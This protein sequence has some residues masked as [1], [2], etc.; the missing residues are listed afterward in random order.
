M[1][2]IT[3]SKIN[4]DSL[5]EELAQDLELMINP[6]S[7]KLIG[8]LRPWNQ[9]FKFLKKIHLSKIFEYLK[10]KSGL[11]IECRIKTVPF[12][13]YRKYTFMKQLWDY[14]FDYTRTDWYRLL[15]QKID[16]GQTVTMPVKGY[17][18][19]NIQHLKDYCLD[20]VNLL[21]SMRQDGY[22]PEKGKDELGVIIGPDGSLIKSSKGRHRLAAAQIT[23][24]EKIP[25]RVKHIHRQWVDSHKIG[26]KKG[27]DIRKLVKLALGKAS[28]MHS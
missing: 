10:P 11:I 19:S 16:N 21:K 6:I 3:I 4:S 7:I 23:G 17:Q 15:K 27:T 9:S 2:N 18:I 26:E 22:L 25:V 12:N 24:I 28:E 14:E 13:E 1:K 5:H 20:Y 8:K